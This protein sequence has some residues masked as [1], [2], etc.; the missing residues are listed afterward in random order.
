MQLITMAHFGEAQGVIETFQLKRSGPDLFK[1]ENLCV[2]IT[3]EGPFEAAVK[4]A[5]LITE[6]KPSQVI[7]LG[8]A[9]SLKDDL[10]VGDVVE[11]RTIYLLQ[12]SKTYFKT[13]EAS[14]TGLDL[15]TSFERLLDPEK[16]GLF[17]GFGALVDREAWGV[18][19]AAKS[20]AVPFLCRKVVSDKAGTL[21]ACELVKGKVEEFS[22]LLA[23]EARKLT[24]V[25]LVK[26]E[27][28]INIP[29]LH[30]TFSMKHR[31]NT[32]LSKLRLTKEMS[33]KELF[34][35]A[36]IDEIL[37]LEISPKEKALRLLEAFEGKLDPFRAPAKKI[38]QDL[39][40][41]AHNLEIEIEAD[42]NLENPKLKVTIEVRNNRELKEKTEK[43]SKLNLKPFERLM[44]GGT[45]VE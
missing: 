39:K 45:H 27:I 19:M 31:L 34:E 20:L 13:F 21:G 15:L 26:P 18:A 40:K 24:S 30:F 41:D 16:A 22:I 35:L 10:D 37:V 44:N 42:P 6:L 25:E 5:S 4:T 7:N 17:R 14:K 3:G 43:L 33:D 12:E 36:G 11:I 8:I 29:G 32:L 2:L 28:Q 9:G 38:I 23:Q 1:G